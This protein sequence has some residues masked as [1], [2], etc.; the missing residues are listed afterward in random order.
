MISMCVQ[1]PWTAWVLLLLLA[2]HRP[3]VV[4]AADEKQAA[5]DTPHSRQKRLLWL[6]PDGRLALP[7]GTSLV[8]TPSLS[9]PFVRYPPDGFFSNMTISLP[10]TIDFDTLGLTD[11]ANPYGVLP[12]ILARSMGRMAGSAVSAY[13]SSLLDAR[14]RN[15]RGVHV[16]STPP[17]EARA[18]LHG[19]ERALLYQV[20]EDFLGT[21]GM[22]GKACVLRA[23][24]EVHGHPL[25][26]FGLIGE[27]LRLFFT[28]SKS[29]VANLLNEY[30]EAEQ[31]GQG[32]GECWRYHRDC[33][34]SLFL[35]RSK[36][37]QEAAESEEV[38]NELEDARD[39][40][41]QRSRDAPSEVTLEQTAHLM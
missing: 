36:Y 23:I 14:R 18:V 35:W 26:H 29:P 20:V 2:G 22:D 40:Q 4:T 19:G 6:T 13:V 33:P 28:A 1:M 37:S 17:P 16:Q 30:V 38:E 10:F 31:A 41:Q 15:T 25:H 12:P 3:S 24:C 7:P 39:E 9:L 8:I 32:D 5:A 11:N 27:F 34:K 21:L